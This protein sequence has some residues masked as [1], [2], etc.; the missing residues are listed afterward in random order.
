MSALLV[1]PQRGERVVSVSPE[2]A[3]WEYVGFEVVRPTRPFRRAARRDQEQ[4]LVAISG[5]SEVVLSGGSRFRLHRGS[6]FA[7]LPDCLYLP[8]GTG[9]QV[10]PEGAGVELAI[11]TAPACEGGDARHIDPGR[12]RVEIRGEGRF[13]RQIRPILMGS[14]GEDPPAAQSLLICEVITPAGNWSSFPPHKHDRDDPPRETRLEETYYHRVQ[15]AGGFG[16]QWVYTEDR[17]IDE[18]IAFGDRDTVLVPRG[19]HTVS[20]PPGYELYYL[21]VMAG[22]VRSWAVVEDDDHA[23]IGASR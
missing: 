23:W 22:P 6:P 18:A 7:D 13:E 11:C 10:A 21:N 16:L 3:G 14:S 19:F 17:E 9:F 2:S 20:A 15:P 5:T 1:R 12:I 8:P 4:C